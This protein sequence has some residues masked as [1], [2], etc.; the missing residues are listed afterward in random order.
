MGK[1]IGQND[2][3][4]A[5]STQTEINAYKDKGTTILWTNQIHGG[6]PVFQIWAPYSANITTWIIKAITNVF[7]NPVSTVFLMLTGSYLSL[8]HI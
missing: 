2:V 4:R 1:T 8:I 6:M 3:T 7:P 5:Q